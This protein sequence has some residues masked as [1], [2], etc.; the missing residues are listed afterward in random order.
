MSKTDNSVLFAELAQSV[1]V[2][3]VEE[4]IAV[5]KRARSE[6]SYIHDINNVLSMICDTLQLDI[7]EITKHHVRS[8]KRKAAIGFC[9][10]FTKKIYKYNYA[11]I[12]HSINL[13][14]SYGM[15]I[16]YHNVIKNAKISNPKSDIDKVI[17]SNYEAICRGVL[18][19]YNK[20]KN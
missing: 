3:G 13:N 6:A 17:S 2:L 14:I 16:K 1:K 11:Q 12:L 15:A 10:H 18:K 9:I 7:K 19:E 5:L 20:N 4:A 8:D